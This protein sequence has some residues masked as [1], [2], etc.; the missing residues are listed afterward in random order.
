MKLPVLTWEAGTVM[1]LARAINKDR[2]F[3]RLP[4]LA[5]ALEEAGC[6]NEGILAHCRGAG[7][8]VRGCWLVDALLAKVPF[9]SSG[10]AA[11]PKPASAGDPAPKA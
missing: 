3:N 10:Q 8:H 4:I 11:A 5:D 6:T 9:P 1:E 2:A 7:P